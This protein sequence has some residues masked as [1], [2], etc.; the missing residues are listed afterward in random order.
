MCERR[1]A[2]LSRPPSSLYLT[3]GNRRSLSNSS[4]RWNKALNMLSIE[5]L[6]WKNVLHPVKAWK[7]LS[8]IK[9]GYSHCV[10]K[11][12]SSVPFWSWISGAPLSCPALPPPWICL[13]R[14]RV[15]TVYICRWD[16]LVFRAQ[17]SCS[18][19][20]LRMEPEREIVSS[21]GKENSL[22]SQGHH[23]ANT[24]LLSSFQSPLPVRY[25][26]AF[27]TKDNPRPALLARLMTMTLH[28]SSSYLFLLV[29][30]ESPPP[31]QQH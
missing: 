29:S 5:T 11:N 30:A 17:S 26:A 6:A 16:T 4:S 2:N 27:W 14:V 10:I 12:T 7:I 20:V 24:I 3:N 18:L 13:S 25:R 23:T 31:P 1:A 15:T 28:L 21:C 8:R 22:E 9:A 19:L